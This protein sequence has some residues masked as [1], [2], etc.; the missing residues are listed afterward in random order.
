MMRAL[1]E[2]LSDFANSNPI[3]ATLA[4]H[5]RVIY[6]GLSGVYCTLVTI[7]ATFFWRCEIAGNIKSSE[8]V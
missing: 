1:L 6:V 2:A 8:S 3:W 7:W 5:Y 4:D